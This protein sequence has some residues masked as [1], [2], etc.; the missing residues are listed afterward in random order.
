MLF[1]IGWV[2]WAFCARVEVCWP[3]LNC[4][5]FV[6]LVFFTT[7]WHQCFWRTTKACFK[8]VC[9]KNTLCFLSWQMLLVL[10]IFHLKAHPDTKN[11]CTRLK[12][13]RPWAQALRGKEQKHNKPLGSDLHA[14]TISVP[15]CGL[16]LRWGYILW[17]R[18]QCI[19]QILVLE[20]GSSFKFYCKHEN[21]STSARY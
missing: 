6:V 17:A 5:R 9:R 12:L 21:K 2:T 13:F 1:H 20:A 10:L 4:A 16:P 7:S 14:G 19:Q 11:A 15:I 8:Q 3:P 18:Q